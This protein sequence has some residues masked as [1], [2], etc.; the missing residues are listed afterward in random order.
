MHFLL[1]IVQKSVNSYR[2][3][4]DLYLSIFTFYDLP[5]MRGAAPA[6]HRGVRESKKSQNRE[7]SVLLIVLVRYLAK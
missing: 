3:Q 5:S 2:Y 1:A 4:K 7:V 6:Q